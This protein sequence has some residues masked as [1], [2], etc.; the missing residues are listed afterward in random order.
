MVSIIIIMT[1]FRLYDS[2]LIVL[3]GRLKIKY[4]WETL[5]TNHTN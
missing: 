1:V 2:L 4:I 3:S 5:L